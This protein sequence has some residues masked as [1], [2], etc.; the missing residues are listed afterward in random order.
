MFGEYLLNLSVVNIIRLI[1]SKISICDTVKPVTFT[2]QLPAIA[3]V[4][5]DSGPWKKDAQ[6]G[7][8]SSFLR[9][10]KGREETARRSLPSQLE[11]TPQLGS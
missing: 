6:I 5:D 10:G 8:W 3:C 2:Q 11:R 9:G 7:K 1:N 4:S